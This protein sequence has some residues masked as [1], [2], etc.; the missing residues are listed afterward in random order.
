M[1]PTATVDA[2]T[3][4][5]PLVHLFDDDYGQL[6]YA[7]AVDGEVFSGEHLNHPSRPSRAH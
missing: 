5:V 3:L 2:S 4:N 7:Q 6:L 1:S